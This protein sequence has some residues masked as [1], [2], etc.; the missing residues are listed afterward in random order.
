MGFF[1]NPTISNSNFQIWNAHF[2]LS[3]L[4]YDVV[5]IWFPDKCYIW[6]RNFG[7]QIVWKPFLSNT[8]KVLAFLVSHIWLYPVTHRWYIRYLHPYVLN[9][10]SIRLHPSY[11]YRCFTYYVLKPKHV[12]EPYKYFKNSLFWSLTNSLR[13]YNCFGTLRIFRNLTNV[14][15]IVKM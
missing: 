2:S 14:K 4:L 3:V 7:S 12:L 9:I 8:T 11:L 5:D 10:Q 15:K 6:A 1:E 13:T